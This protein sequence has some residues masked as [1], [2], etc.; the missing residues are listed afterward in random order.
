MKIGSIDLNGERRLVVFQDDLVIDLNAAYQSLI[1]RQGTTN[2]QLQAD[3]ELPSNLVQ[4]LEKGECAQNAAKRA[5]D[6]ALTHCDVIHGYVYPLADV[7][8]AASHRPPK[9]VCTGNNYK[10]YRKLLGIESSPVPLLI[11]KSPS[12]V[13]GHEETV[14]IPEGYG[15]VFHEWE[16]SCVI[17]KRSRSVPRERAHEIIY[18][19]TILNDLTGR[20]FEATNRELKPWGKN[21]DTFAP[22][23]PWIVTKDEMREDIYNL[24]T[25]RRR[26]GKVACESH[27]GNMDFGF[28]EIIEFVTTFMTLEPGDVVTTST[29][30][31]GPIGPGDVIEA[32]IEGIG[33]LR[34][35]VEK[36]S[37]AL[38]YAELARLKQTA[39]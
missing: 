28:E 32:E 3:F 15:T 14:Y 24:R 12:A 30:P 34:N 35:P 2:A 25:L 29:P 10:D 27:T 9:I 17:S 20:A 7:T 13:I 4:F 38:K 33:V 36:L 19:Y 5:M 26:N 37:V 31:A 23:G 11:M 1:E 22:M 16:F 8:F 6:H 39:S 18:G 21:M